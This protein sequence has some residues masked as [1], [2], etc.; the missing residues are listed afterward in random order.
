[1][2]RAVLGVISHVFAFW[3]SIYLTFIAGIG[4]G[5]E[6]VAFAGWGFAIA[7]IGGRL[8]GVGGDWRMAAAGAAVGAV[9]VTTPRVELGALEVVVPYAVAL[10]GFHARNLLTTTRRS[11]RPERTP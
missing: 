7:V 10:S 5:W 3:L 1:M 6:F 9:A 8:L 11:I 2:V 4:N